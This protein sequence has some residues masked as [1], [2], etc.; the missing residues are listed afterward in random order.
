MREIVIKTFTKLQFSL[1]ALKTVNIHNSLFF[2]IQHNDK[3]SRNF[4]PPDGINTFENNS[5]VSYK[6]E[7][8]ERGGDLLSGVGEKLQ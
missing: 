1:T 3:V 7:A 2:Q 5:T 6:M 8:K 4:I